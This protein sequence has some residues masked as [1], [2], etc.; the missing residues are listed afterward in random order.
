MEYVYINFLRDVTQTKFASKYN[1]VKERVWVKKAA[2][3]TYV[4]WS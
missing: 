4:E 1:I 3:Y 2:A